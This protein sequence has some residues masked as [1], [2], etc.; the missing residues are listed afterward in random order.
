MADTVNGIITV[1][2][3]EADY[4]EQFSKKL[5]EVTKTISL[6]GF[7]PG[8]VPPTLVEKMYGK[9]ILA[10]TLNELLDKSVN[11][12]VKE[13]NIDTVSNPVP[14][15]N[16]ADFTAKDFE[17]KFKIGVIPTF[18]LPELTSFSVPTYKPMV[19]KARIEEVITM[20]GKQ[21]GTT[22][23][24]ETIE[25]G[26]FLFGILK[27]AD[28]TFSKDTGFSTDT[29]LGDSINNFV[30]K[31]IGD[32]IEIDVQT[33]FTHE[34]MHRVTMTKHG[35]DVELTGT[36]TFTLEKINR[37]AVSEMNEEFFEKVFPGDGITTEEAFNTKI[38]DLLNESAVSDQN[39]YTNIS[40]KKEL[41]ES[42]SFELPVDFIK[43][44]LLRVKENA[45]EEDKAK[46]LELFLKG[47][48]E[49]IIL[50]K[51]AKKYEVNVEMNEVMGYTREMIKEQFRQYGMANIEDDMLDDYV[52]RYLAD[53]KD[54]NL[55]NM[56]ER[57]FEAKVSQL[58]QDKVQPVVSEV[59]M[60]EF[61]E[62]I[63]ALQ[64]E[65]NS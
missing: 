65:L 51:I 40:A 39:Y 27:N 16:E 9:S 15:A 7:R 55:S 28:G 33:A 21:Y 12:F 31:T 43:E 11:D 47:M 35:E 5:K 30:G 14:E 63:Q 10:D 26:D 19:N 58:I 48:K 1:N 4:K 53:K 50:S 18:E 60:D 32:A 42:I 41:A 59:P 45:T 13:Q 20:L 23:N 34:Q 29:L 49:N 62:K 54:N 3:V 37:T 22:T 56:Y 36:M 64:A 52:K 2:L 25:K 8:K 46:N 17:F 57:T 44:N 38:E 24:P 6:K 61:K